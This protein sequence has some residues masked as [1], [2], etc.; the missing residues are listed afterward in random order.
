MGERSFTSTE[1]Y[2]EFDVKQG[3]FSGSGG[4]NRVFGGYHVD[5]TNLKFTAVA[6]T[7]TGLPRCGRAAGRSEFPESVGNDEPRGNSGRRH[8]LVCDG[9]PDPHIQSD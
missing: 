4:G 3:R 5:G 7:K 8:T 9:Q 6:S 1:P 2:L